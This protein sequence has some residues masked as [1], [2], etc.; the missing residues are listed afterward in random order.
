LGGL[1]SKRLVENRQSQG[2]LD[3]G[4]ATTQGEVGNGFRQMLPRMGP[5][6][7]KSG[8]KKRVW[9]EIA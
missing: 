7:G 9:D 5:V 8:L 1:F 3:D 6:P 2:G 4:V